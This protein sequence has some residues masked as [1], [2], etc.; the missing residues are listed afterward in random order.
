M[1]MAT[2][3]AK[4]EA[5]EQCLALV[6]A[7]RPSTNEERQRLWTPLDCV[8]ERQMTLVRLVQIAEGLVANSQSATWTLPVTIWG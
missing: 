7:E 2:G 8:R 1:N 5:Y 3:E 6:Q 4:P